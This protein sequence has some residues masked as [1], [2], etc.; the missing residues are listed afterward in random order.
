MPNKR[1]RILG[2]IAE[3]AGDDEFG[4]Q[5][6]MASDSGGVIHLTFADVSRKTQPGVLGSV[7]YARGIP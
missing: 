7:M 5:A 4:L 6:S 1:L 3:G 2:L